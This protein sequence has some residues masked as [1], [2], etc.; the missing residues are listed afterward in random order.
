MVWRYSKQF[1][2]LEV[3]KKPRITDANQLPANGAHISVLNAYAVAC[4][5]KLLLHSTA[6]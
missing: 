6:L 1:T 2:E 3:H 4:L 5:Q